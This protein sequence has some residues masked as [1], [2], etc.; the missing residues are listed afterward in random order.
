MSDMAH[1]RNHK[2]L[3]ISN[4][5]PMDLNFLLYIENIYE[6]YHG[7]KEIFPGKYLISNEQEL[8]EYESFKE[9]LSTSWDEIVKEYEQQQYMDNPFKTIHFRDCFKRLFREDSVFHTSERVWKTFSLW[10]WSEYGVKTYMERYSDL[11]MPEMAEQIWEGLFD[12]DIK[13]GAD[14]SLYVML[15]F[16]QPVMVTPMNSNKL[17]FS[18]IND[19]AYKKEEIIRNV[20]DLF[21]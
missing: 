4:L 1:S 6:C 5:C 8:L 16:K 3:N 19:F 20:V 10:W 13:V 15:L 2:K 14:N 9:N 7:E 17:Y 12:K 18:S 11:F 21:V